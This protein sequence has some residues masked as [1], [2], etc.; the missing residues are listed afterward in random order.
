MNKIWFLEEV[1]LFKIL[2]PHYYAEY[3]NTHEFDVYPKKEFIYF[4]EEAST[5]VYLIDKGKVK[6]GYYNENGDEVIKAILSRGEIFG[7]KSILGE[8]KHNDF[9]QS[10]IKDTSICSISV[11][12]LQGLML[13]N[14]NLSLKIYKF[15]GVRFKRLE[16]RLELL[17]FKD[18]RTRLIEYLQELEKDFGQV[19]VNG[20]ILIKHPY[21]Q[22]DIAS[23][24][25]ISRPSLNILMN[26]LKEEHYLDFHRKEIILKK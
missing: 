14:R 9:A 10:L 24:I 6:I 18:A 26:N 16:R 1:N 20:D 22:K 11:N 3:K 8:I 12:E 13:K 25:G 15:I 2:C 21:T 19:L 5:K 23:L 17:L 7:E 4:T